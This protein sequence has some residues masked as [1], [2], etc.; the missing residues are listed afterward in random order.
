MTTLQLYTT[1]GCH[2]C[3]QALSLLEPLRD[4]YSFSV[5]LVDIADSD[6]LVERYGIRIPVLL[7][8]A[9]QCELGWPFDEG[10]LRDFLAS[11]VKKT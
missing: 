10:R 5:E 11:Q 8:P 9:N 4:E 6:E 3:E 2:L 1:S 7:C